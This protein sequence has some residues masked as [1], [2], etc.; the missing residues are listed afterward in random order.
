[1]S[2]LPTK[3]MPVRAERRRRLQTPEY[4]LAV[5]VAAIENLEVRCQALGEKLS[6]LKEAFDT[7]RSCSG[8]GIVFLDRDAYGE[9]VC[10]GKQ[11][12]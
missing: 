5:A 8:C 1:M 4:R 6:E 10:G 11:G 7:L 9:H 3:E 12:R 2:D